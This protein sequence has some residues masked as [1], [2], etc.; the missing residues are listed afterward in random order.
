MH[1]EDSNVTTLQI[2]NHLYPTYR[3]IK[4]NDLK[5]NYEFI[6]QL[7]CPSNPVDNLLKKIEDGNQYASYRNLSFSD[8]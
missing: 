8:L 6:N 5:R 3:Q 2:L 1:T 7:W 4:A